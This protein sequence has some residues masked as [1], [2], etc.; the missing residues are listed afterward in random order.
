MINY[1]Q[2]TRTKVLN[3]SLKP[4]QIIKAT[5]PITIKLFQCKLLTHIDSLVMDVDLVMFFQLLLQCF[6]SHSCIINKP[7]LHLLTYP[8]FGSVLHLLFPS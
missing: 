1:Y 7:V 3:F 4:V 6:C 5:L 8:M 2:T